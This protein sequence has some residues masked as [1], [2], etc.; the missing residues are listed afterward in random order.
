MK[1][2]SVVYSQNFLRDKSLV[3]DLVKRFG[4]K[5]DDIV[6]EIGAG[7]GIITDVLINNSKKVVAFEI[8]KDL[9]SKLLVKFNLNKKLDL[10]FGDF[11]TT[12][13]PETP[14][15]VFSNIPFNITA[16]VIRKLTQATNPP[17]ETYLIV[18]EEAVRKFV[19][20]P[21]DEKNSQVS[22]L[23]KPWFDLDVVYK[24]RRDDFVPRPRVDTVLL[25]ICKLVNPLIDISKKGDYYDF[26]V[27]TFNQFKPNIID[28]L[29]GVF[30][31]NV[32][33]NLAKKYD[34]STNAKPSQLEVKQWVGIFEHYLKNVFNNK[35]VRG[36]YSKLL[37]QQSKLEKINRTRVDKN[38]RQ[39]VVTK[40]RNTFF[41]Q[42][43]KNNQSPTSDK[44]NYRK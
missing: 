41:Q 17:D 16:N 18:Q 2:N 19:G 7:Q 27:Y 6:Y 30:G 36:S 28:G 22:I 42:K 8:D 5:P 34:F 31:R 13:L 1:N 21:Y 43:V 23:L 3:F 10:R 37:L 35:L 26:I 11:L 39:Q 40:N 20:R 14:F 15:K 12:S 9:Y 32:M 38:W 44:S 33:L 24:F 4:I 25:S 29:S